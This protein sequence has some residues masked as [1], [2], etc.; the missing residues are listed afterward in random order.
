MAIQSAPTL[1]ANTSKF[2][3]SVEGT[4]FLVA[5][6]QVRE[7][8]SRPYAIHLDLAYQAEVDFEDI[9][10]KPALLTIESDE[11]DRYFHGIVSDFS[12]TGT[13]GRRLLYRVQVVPAVALLALEQDCRIFQNLTVDAIVSQVLKDAGIAADSF[14]FRLQG[15]YPQRD[16]CV[17]YRETDLDF[18]SR[19]L[20]AEGIFYF[21]E[22]STDRHAIVF[23]DSTV[24]V[25]PVSGRDEVVFNPDSGLVAE[26]EAVGEFER[27]RRLH[28]GKYALQDYRFKNPALNLGT[29]VKD[30]EYDQ[31]EFYDYP[32]GYKTREEGNQLV[33][34]RLQQAV[35]S[36]DVARGRSNIARLVP[37]FTF[38]LSG[39]DINSFNKEYLITEIT[40]EGNQP[41]VLGERA[42]GTSSYGN[43]FAAVPSS[44]TI[45]PKQITPIPVVQGVHTAIVTGPSGEEI[46][47]DEHG[48]V[49]VQ[50]HWDRLGKKDDKS[51]CW[52]RVSQAWAGAGWG[53]I[54]IPRIGQEVIV[55][56]IEGNPDRP[57]ITGRVYHGTN[58]PPY[59]LPADKTKSTIKSDSSKG[60]G[61]SNEIR[62]EDKK[63]SE[64]IYLHGQKDWNIVIENDKNQ[65]IGSNETL[66]VGSNR[67]K[68]V[69]ADQSESIAVNKNI[70]VGGNHNET[71]GATYSLA[72][73]ANKSENVGTFSTETVGAAKALTIGA[74]YQVTVGAALNE[75]VGAAKAEEVGA[76]KSVVVG[77]NL[78]CSVGAD[79]TTTVGGKHDEEVSEAYDLKAK[80]VRIIAEDEIALKTGSAQITMQK[81]GDI[82]LKGKNIT[83]KGS[84]GIT[85]KGPNIKEN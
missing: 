57:I 41:Q 66:Q 51:S 27:T 43:S 1:M 78:T 15:N 77:S 30:K 24:C 59:Q 7:Q 54:F 84:G 79:L 4:E 71:V 60:G 50:F 73:A 75:T 14:E 38:R 49:K 28:T 81:N 45:R 47:T 35:L 12:Q 26:E 74:A 21:F 64:E 53:A 13:K 39:H 3:F 48:R 23:G 18:I 72:V 40:H 80:K 36:G 2:T 17:Q 5:A 63:G 62:F 44:V 8:I 9:I 69:G 42:D 29:H 22:H 10:G 20:E 25:K 56:F 83:I 67:T 76:S 52:I 37:G 58:T 31:Y 46:H 19:L 85:V 33:K 65:S 68:T 70:H 11:Q 6:F 82:T 55:D 34:V 32:G 61:G 16:Y